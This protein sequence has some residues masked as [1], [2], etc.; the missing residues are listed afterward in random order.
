MATHHLQV[1]LQRMPLLRKPDRQEDDLI[2]LTFFGAFQC[3]N[4]LQKQLA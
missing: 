4:V 3:D 2:C 1:L